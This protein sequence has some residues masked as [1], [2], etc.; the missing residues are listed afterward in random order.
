MTGRRGRNLNDVG[1]TASASGPVFGRRQG[2]E[3]PFGPA[4]RPHDGSAETVEWAEAVELP[5]AAPASMAAASPKARRIAA[6]PGR[7]GLFVCAFAFGALLLPALL[8]SFPETP[9]A[10]TV[11]NGGGYPVRLSTINASLVSHGDGRLLRVE[12]RISNP[13]AV[14]A[15]VPPLRID[16]ADR[17]AGLR[18]RTLQTSVDRLNAGTSIDFVT[19]VAVPDEAKGDVRVG[20]VE[21]SSEGGR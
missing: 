21:T 17:S 1:R 12:G 6:M 10:A 19:M 15:A 4:T 2:A 11:S 16:F 20:F 18:S 13:A 14:A 8:V 5:R 9:V 3:E 7:I